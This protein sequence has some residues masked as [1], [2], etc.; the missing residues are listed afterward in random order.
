MITNETRDMRLKT[1]R[2]KG[3]G[4]IATTTD[5]DTH[6]ELAAGEESVRERAARDRGAARGEEVELGG[7]EAWSMAWGKSTPRASY[8]RVNFVRFVA[9]GRTLYVYVP[10]RAR[11]LRDVEPCR[12]R[13]AVSV[14]REGGEHSE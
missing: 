1:A 9:K 12:L 2:R 3:G 6:V 8:A 13:M 4:R 14:R 7:G 11:C 10:R 5:D